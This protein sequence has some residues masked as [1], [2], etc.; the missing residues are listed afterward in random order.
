[1]KK[2]LIP[3]ALLLIGACGNHP[4]TD[5]ASFVDIESFFYADSVF[6]ENE[7]AE[8]YS[9]YQAE[10]ELPV[11][12]NKALLDSILAWMFDA[13]DKTPT[14]FVKA[15]KERFF[16]EEGNEP[17]AALESN[18]LLVEQTDR[19]VTY[20]AEGSLYTGGAHPLPW[21]T[22]TTFSKKDGSRMG[23]NMFDQPEQ[24]VEMVA[25]AIRSQYFGVL[26]S[27][28]EEEYLLEPVEFFHLPYAEPWVE[29][30]SVVFCYGS[31]EI[32]PFSAGLPYCTLSKT[33][34]KPYLN[35]KGKSLFVF[36]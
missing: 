18:Y 4:K 20:L 28:E 5:N 9:K 3:V 13:S 34:L 21:Y 17:L 24:L 35:E 33:Q 6:L 8:G 19:Y 30:D 27:E 36:D 14:E 32:A 29:N 15:E 2:L 7:Y 1:M 26:D 22:G 31:Y 10:I 11:T 16:A 12:E 25:E 23:Y